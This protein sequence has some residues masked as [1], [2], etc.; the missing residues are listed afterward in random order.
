MGMI[1]EKHKRFNPFIEKPQDLVTTHEQIR[2]GFLNIALEKNRVGDTFV[3]N[4]FVF[5]TMAANTLNPYDFLKIVSI[6][7]FLLA[8]AGLSDKSMQYLNE[9]DRTI[10][11][12]ELIEKFLKPAGNNY[13]DEVIYRYLLIKGDTVGGIMRNRIGA[14]GQERFIRIL[15]SCMNVQGITYEWLPNEKSM[16]TWI[17]KSEDDTGIEKKIKAIHWNCGFGD[18]VLAF[19]L[20]IPVIK[21]NVD[22]CLFEGNAASYDSG[23]IVKDTGRIIMLGELKGGIDPAGAD[24]HWKTANTALARIRTGFA[25]VG[26]T[27]QTSFVGAAIENSMA[28]EIFLQLQTGVLTNAANLTNDNQLVEYCSWLLRI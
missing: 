9:E 10:A 5:K 19:N 24:E 27:V 3:K 8:A 1:Q 26:Y 20:N 11:I 12:E 6:R 21:K 14:L 16:Y 28:D 18:K 15:L 17:C 4:A 7:P 13:I 2:T 25:D 23:K 22:I